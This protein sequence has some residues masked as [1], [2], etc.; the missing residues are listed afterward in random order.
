[1]R[2]KKALIVDSDI[3]FIRGVLEL[4]FDVKYLKGCEIG[5]KEVVD[6]SAL[7]VRTRTKCDSE[8]LEGS[9]V[10]A[11]FTATAGMDHLDINYCDERGLSYFNA[12]GSNALGV[13][14]W[15]IAALI[16]FAKKEKFQLS[17]RRVAIIGAGN[18]G[19]ALALL[20]EQLGVEVFRHD[21]PKAIVDRE[22]HYYTL[23][24]IYP[25]ADLYTL[26]LPFDQTTKGWA[27]HHFFKK[28]KEGSLFFN[29]S[30]GEVVD[31]SALLAQ[32]DRLGGVALDV[33]LNEPK[34]DKE[35]LK[36]VELATPHIAGYSIEGKLNATVMTI[37]SIGNYFSIEELS[38]Y[39][40][41]KPA[42][43]SLPTLKELRAAGG[44]ISSLSLLVESYF[45]IEK[46]SERLKRGVELF[47]EIRSSYN[48]RHQL[49]N[50][51]VEI[52]KE[53]LK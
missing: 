26:H 46:E 29:S 27:S 8:L 3:P 9:Q 44:G 19:G 38:N 49:P 23:E 1:M 31:Q 24:E 2:R 17:E 35:L 52:T 11:I 16:W 40:I 43:P 32:R 33:W 15:V 36:S 21:P 51:F 42:Q 18:I 4:Y 13:V 10:E 28:I 20:L 14:Q 22:H 7:V 12:A 47:E 39:S 6:A 48:Y 50:S 37:R 5:A 34:I 53:L 41:D 45:D 25:V 30:R